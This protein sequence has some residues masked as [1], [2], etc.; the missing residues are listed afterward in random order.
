MK[1]PKLIPTFFLLVLGQ[2]IPSQASQASSCTFNSPL[3][4][5]G[6]EWQVNSAMGPVYLARREQGAWRVLAVFDGTNGKYH[7]SWANPTKGEYAAVDSVGTSSETVNI[8]DD[9]NQLAESDRNHFQPTGPN[10]AASSFHRRALAA[11]ARP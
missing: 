1:F 8:S 6:T 7:L 10:F 11:L 5:S 2:V 3:S 9:S 4:Y